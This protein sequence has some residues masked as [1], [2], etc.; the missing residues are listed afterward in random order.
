VIHVNYPHL[1]GHTGSRPHTRLRGRPRRFF[2]CVWPVA[3]TP[4]AACLPAFD[5]SSLPR[6]FPHKESSS[7]ALSYVWGELRFVYPMTCN[8]QRHLLTPNLAQAL[9]TIFTSVNSNSTPLYRRGDEM[10][11]WADGIC[12]N[13]KDNVEKS[14]QLQS[15]AESASG[16][17][18]TRAFCARTL[19]PSPIGILS[20]SDLIRFP[21]LYWLP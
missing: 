3:R 14:T 6:P 18:C 2:S 7:V 11:L 19:L 21:Y 20:S 17:S 9:R 10:F 16:F 12:I 5:G 4:A 1:V 13:Q 8:S 15:F